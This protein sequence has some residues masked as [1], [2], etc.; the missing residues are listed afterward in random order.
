MLLS[1]A[2]DAVPKGGALIVYETI[3]D[4]DRSVNAFGLMM[5]LNVLVETEGDST[6]RGPIAS[7]GCV[8][9]VFGRRQWI[10]S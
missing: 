3:I 9:P 1:K 6:T 4:D 5:S 10:I 2:Y 7:A 8:R